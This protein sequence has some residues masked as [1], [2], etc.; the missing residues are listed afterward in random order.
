MSD[1]K[2]HVTG[3]PKLTTAV[4][5]GSTPSGSAAKAFNSVCGSGKS[6]TK[7]LTV[8][9]MNTNKKH[10]YTCSRKYSPVTVSLGGKDVTFKYSTK[11]KAVDP[12]KISSVRK[13]ISKKNVVSKCIKKCKK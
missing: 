7:L 12:K 5:R 4:F 9:D 1:R 11:I 6:C 10:S 13:S 2:F 3:S 8:T